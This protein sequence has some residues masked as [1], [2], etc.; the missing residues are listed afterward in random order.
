MFA[1][2]SVCWI[3][4]IEKGKSKDQFLVRGGQYAGRVSSPGTTI[5]KEPTAC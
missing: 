1:E 2:F 4:W 5:L 3:D